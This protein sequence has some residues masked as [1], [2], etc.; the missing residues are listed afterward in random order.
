MKKIKEL[1]KILYE[2]G[3]VHI[4]IGSFITKLVAFFGSIFLVR[5]LS[6]WDY[7]VLGYIENIYGYIFIFAG[8]G[9]SNAILRYVVLGNDREEKYSYYFY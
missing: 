1:I 7:G 9:L 8:M 4:F 6:K 5:I 3:V 2:K